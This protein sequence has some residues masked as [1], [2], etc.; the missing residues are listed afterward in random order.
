MDRRVQRARAAGLPAI[1]IPEFG[2]A[3]VL[4][5]LAELTGSGAVALAAWG[6]AKPTRRRWLLRLRRWTGTTVFAPH[7]GIG[8]MGAYHWG[9]ITAVALGAIAGF[10]TCGWSIG[11]PLS[12]IYGALIGA[13]VA[14]VTWWLFVVVARRRI[15]GRPVNVA[16]PEV[17]ALVVLL[18]DTARRGAGLDVPDPSLNIPWAAKQLTY[19]IVDQDLSDEEFLQLRY[20]AQ[21][22]GHAVGQALRAQSTLDAITQVRPDR[23]IS[24]EVAAATENVSDTTARLTAHAVAMDEVAEHIRT[25]RRYWPAAG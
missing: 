2:E 9:E 25:I 1:E 8:T 13:A 6:A 14:W 22:L 23:E 19:Q 17:M 3:G 21:M 24:A 15:V 11:G 10:L 12:V 16:D 5:W 20:R 7:V 18:A 4:M